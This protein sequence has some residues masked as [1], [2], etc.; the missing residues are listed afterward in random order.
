ME[1][2]KLSTGIVVLITVLIV[3]VITLSII[4]IYKMGTESNQTG[5]NEEKIQSNTTSSVNQTGNNAITEN[6][7]KTNTTVNARNSDVKVSYTFERV[8]NTGYNMGRRNFNITVNGVKCYNIESTKIQIEKEDEESNL[9]VYELKYI[10]DVTHNSEYIL[11]GLYGYLPTS[12]SI[13][14]YVIDTS[15][16]VIGKFECTNATTF[17]LDGKRLELEINEDSVIDYKFYIE[18][19][20]NYGNVA[21]HKYTVQNGK[22]ID[23]IVEVYD[24]SRVVRAGASI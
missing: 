1:K 14:Y 4:L 2:K 11:L 20:E 16:Q 9:K 13:T 10:K 24:K 23:T 3:A 19:E 8:E 18:N 7:N 22:V 21:K 15:A 6:Q 5:R 17:T 12:K